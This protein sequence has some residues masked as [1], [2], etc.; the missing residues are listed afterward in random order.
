MNISTRSLAQNQARIRARVWTIGLLF[1]VLVFF[2][3]VLQAVGFRLPNQDPEGIAR[4]NAFAATADNPSAIYYNPAGITQ[5]EG[6]QFRA[7]IYLISADSEYTSPSGVKAETDASFQAVPQMYYVNS[8]KNLPLSFGLGVYA[9]Y[10]LA[11]DWGT[12]APFRTLA[13]KG[14][15]LYATV[16]PVVAWRVFPTLSLAV[17]P[18]INYSQVEFKRGIGFVANDL[19]I[20]KGDGWDYGFNAGLLWK[21]HRMWSFGLNYRYATEIDYSGH[22]ETSPAAPFPPYYPSA[23]TQASLRFPQFVAAGISFRPTEN[24]NLEFDLDW[25]DWDSLNKTVFRGTP[26]HGTPFGDPVFVW[27]YTSSFMYNFGITRQLCK[28]YFATV[29][30]IY[31]ENSSPDKDFNP[32][33]PDS[34][35]HLGSLGFGHHGQRWDWAVGYTLAYNSGRD[36]KSDINPLANGTYRTL[37]NAVNLAVTYKF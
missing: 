19:F 30:Y 31:S 34:D 27:N 25:T 17:G 13:E 26:F 35:L 14:E 11:L 16:N 1:P 20:V 7:G 3:I 10:G 28:G 5:L 36:V 29:G 21:P 6:Q 2:P 15:L 37:N 22:S 9:P 8:L 18:T 12:H 24:W 23:R 4:G 32:I 33:V